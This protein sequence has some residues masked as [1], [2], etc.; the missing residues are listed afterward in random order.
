ALK[1]VD[2][3]I[4]ITKRLEELYR[5]SIDFQ[6]FS[7]VVPSGVDFELFHP[8]NQKGEKIRE[9]LGFNNSV[10]VGYVGSLHPMRE[11]GFLVNAFKAFTEN[12]TKDFRLVFVGDGIDMKNLKRLTEKSNLQDKIQFV[13]Q[14]PHEKVGEWISAFDIGV[15]H[16]PNKLIFKHSFPLKVLEYMAC[17]KPVLASNIWAHEDVVT[18]GKTGMLYS[19]KSTESFV[20]SLQMLSSLSSSKTMKE[21]VECAKHFSWENV[22]KSLLNFYRGLLKL[23]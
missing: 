15:S 13:G 4:F 6:T 7:T 20:D 22:S 10:I 3:V 9:K 17:G 11:L 19:P 21:C 1:R 2:G 5:R 14:I 8:Q 12:S 18:P 23:G 16:L